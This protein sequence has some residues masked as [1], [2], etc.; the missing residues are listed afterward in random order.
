M[1]CKEVIGEN[2]CIEIVYIFCGHGSCW[3]TQKDLSELII[4][5]KPQIA[6][7]EYLHVVLH[8]SL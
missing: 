4:T 5:A 2:E 8:P 3:T 7:E 1:L 6:D